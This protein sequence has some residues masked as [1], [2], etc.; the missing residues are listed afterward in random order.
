MDSAAFDMSAPLAFVME[1]Y[2][3]LEKTVTGAKSTVRER[4]YVS[5]EIECGIRGW[6]VQ[7][8]EG[9]SPAAKGAPQKKA[10]VCV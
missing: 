3:P 6:I 7:L 2:L 10:A 9:K 4:P 1:V 8:H 5:D